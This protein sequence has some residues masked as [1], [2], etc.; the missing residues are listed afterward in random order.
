MC[1]RYTNKLTWAEIVAL[2]A[3]SSGTPAQPP[4]E[5]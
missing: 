1:G 3:E 4:A 5:V 2:S